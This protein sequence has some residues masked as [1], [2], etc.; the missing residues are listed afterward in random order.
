M[1]LVAGSDITMVGAKSESEAL[2]LIWGA[3][4]DEMD[5]PHRGSPEQ[6]AAAVEHMKRAAA[7]W[8]EAL[9]SADNRSAYCDKWVYE[10]CGYER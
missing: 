2:Y 1:H 4:T 8:L 10:E 7:E 3:L 6:N 5:A 9:P